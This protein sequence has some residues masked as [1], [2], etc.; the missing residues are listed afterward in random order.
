[1]P[2][3]IISNVLIDLDRALASCAALPAF[4]QAL[5]EARQSFGERFADGAN[6]RQL[7]HS[8]ASL[9]DGTHTLI[10]TAGHHQQAGGTDLV[11]AVTL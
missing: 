7:V 2:E 11:R 3:S 8:A 6:V 5:R 4:K 10:V 9:S 1:M